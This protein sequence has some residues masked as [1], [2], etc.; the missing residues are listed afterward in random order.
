M[1]YISKSRLKEIIQQAPEGSESKE[2]VKGLVAA[3]HSVEGLNSQKPSVSLPQGDTGMTANSSQQ[4]RGEENVLDKI[5]GVPGAIGRAAVRTPA[6]IA[7]GF[8]PAIEKVAGVD[9]EEITRRNVEGRDFGFLGDNIRPFG[10][11]ASELQQQRNSG[12]GVT[13]GDVFKTGGRMAADIAGGQAEL[14]SYTI[15]PL[16]ITGKGFTGFKNLL[17]GTTGVSSLVAG[18]AAGQSLGEGESLGTAAAKAAGGYV[19]ST[20]TF[21]MMRF[22][23]NLFRNRGAELIQDDPVRKASEDLNQIMR[24]TV[25]TNPE[26][27]DPTFAANQRLQQSQ[28]ISNK[29]KALEE[30]FDDKMVEIRNRSIDKLLPNVDNPNLATHNV[31]RAVSEE[32][33]NIFRK[34]V[35]QLYGQVRRSDVKTD[36]L[37]MTDDAIAKAAK[38]FGIDFNAQTGNTIT[39][40]ELNAMGGYSALENATEDYAALKSF[41]SYMQD[42]TAKGAGVPDVLRIMENSHQYMIGAS[43]A[44]V[45]AMKNMVSALRNDLRGNLPEEQVKLWDEAHNAWQRST[46]LYTDSTLNEVKNSGFADAIVDGIMSSKPGPTRDLLFNALNQGGSKRATQDLLVHTVLRRAKQ[47]SN[48]DAN[49]YISNFQKS[50]YNYETRSS[51]L[52]NDQSAMLDDFRDFTAQNFDD[53]I[54]DM[55][56]ALDITPQEYRDMVANFDKLDVFDELRKGNGESVAENFTLMLQKDP[57]KIGR[58]I[59]EFGDKER[60]VLGSFVMRDLFNKRKAAIVPDPDNPSREIVQDSFLETYEQAYVS[61]RDAQIRTGSDT[62]YNMFSTKEIET[63]EN[64][65]QVLNDVR[66]LTTPTERANAYRALSAV[67]AVLY[68]KLG[69]IT[70]SARSVQKTFA[71]SVGQ[72]ATA[73]SKQEVQQTIQKYLEDGY[74]SGEIPIDEPIP[75]L[76]ERLNARFLTPATGDAVTNDEPNE[77]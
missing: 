18:S 66:V 8:A 20:A 5:V 6:R 28:M 32:N 65:F 46:T 7:S 62:L 71:P 15:A 55:Q 21:G 72:S 63:I 31:Y 16:T 33:G 4:F 57:E 70:G 61:I 53:T 30:R 23:G 75:E 48:E 9:Q 11:Q 59:N 58:V 77:E 40:E 41:V 51:Y 29:G 38:E 1:A 60:E 26:L 68:A 19:A 36:K 17:K 13:A 42:E 10:Y 47:M 44:E 12:E 45:N 3:G 2:I 43:K 64:G 27:L 25:E 52:T 56:N 14:A 49:K 67:T 22:A 35:D 73:P 69:Y 39:P 24:E 50:A 76:I 54:N 34:E 74:N 37:K